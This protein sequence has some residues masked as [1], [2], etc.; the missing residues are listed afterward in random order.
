MLLSL[1][2]PSAS[3]PVEDL[4]SRY[5]PRGPKAS[6]RD[7]V[8]T[9]K[10]ICSSNVCVCK[11]SLMALV[12]LKPPPDPSPLE[13][14][15]ARGL[16]L[17]FSFTIAA[18]RWNLDVYSM[19]RARSVAR[20]HLMYAARKHFKS[21]G[22]QPCTFVFARCVVTRDH[23]GRAKA[24][25]IAPARERVATKVAKHPLPT[26]SQSTGMPWTACRVGKIID[27]WM[28]PQQLKATRRP[29]RTHHNKRGR[30][31]LRPTRHH[32]GVAERIFVPVQ[33]WASQ[34]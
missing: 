22:F 33:E 8:R 13:P 23:A 27:R 10:I 31:A 5:A 3:L 4:A 1:P 20:M 2:T 15:L 32:D 16:T 12:L 34:P 14:R 25:C 29:M 11:V 28:S 6:R 17:F 19:E 9:F 21:S 18:K 7:R 24:C 30:V 26:A